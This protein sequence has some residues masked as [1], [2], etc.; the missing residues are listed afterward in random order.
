MCINFFMFRTKWPKKK[1][2]HLRETVFTVVHSWTG[3]SPSGGKNMRYLVTLCPV[4]KQRNESWCSA[5]TVAFL[6]YFSLLLF[7]P[8]LQ[9]TGWCCQ[10]HGRGWHFSL[11]LFGNSLTDPPRSKSPRWLLIRSSWQSSL[12]ITDAFFYLQQKLFFSS[13]IV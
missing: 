5:A 7:S 6:F 12:I 13:C 10:P 2:N 1:K 3:P 11:S 9:F 8:E 4:R